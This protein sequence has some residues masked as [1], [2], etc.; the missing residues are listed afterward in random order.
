MEN[1][2]EKVTLTV[3][4]GQAPERLDR[5]LSRCL[6]ARD[7]SRSR[8]QVL[9]KEEGVRSMPFNE[10]KEGAGGMKDVHLEA[11]RNPNW[12]RSNEKGKE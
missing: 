5:F 6:A 7:L 9:L 2:P 11:T 3:P 1:T 10:Q 4:D 12:K 8:I